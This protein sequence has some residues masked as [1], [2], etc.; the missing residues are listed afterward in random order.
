MMQVKFGSTDQTKLKAR[1]DYQNFLKVYN[2]ESRVTSE[3]VLGLIQ[4]NKY[5][6]GPSSHYKQWLQ[7]TIKALE[8]ST[9]PVNEFGLKMLKDQYARL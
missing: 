3:E 7:S 6:N 1:Q 2:S 5:L 9:V 8:V 4:M